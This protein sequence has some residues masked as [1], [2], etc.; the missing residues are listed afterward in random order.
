MSLS[1]RRARLALAAVALAC[2]LCAASLAQAQVVF[3]NFGPGDT[4]DTTIGYTGTHITS[5]SGGAFTTRTDVQGA[6]RITVSATVIPDPGS[7]A[8]LFGLS[9]TGSVFTFRCMR[10]RKK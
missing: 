6:F 5:Q 4:F 10:C 7:L 3:D 9:V 2:C 1:F 8:W